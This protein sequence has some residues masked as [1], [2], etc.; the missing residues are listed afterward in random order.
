MSMSQFFWNRWLPSGYSDLGPVQIPPYPQI[1][2]LTDRADGSQWLVSFNATTS[3]PE[4]LSISSIFASIQKSEGARV[5]GIDDGPYIGNGDYKL[6]IR[7]GRI[8]LEY[9]PF[10]NGI[11]DFNAP[12]IYAET[13]TRSTRLVRIDSENPSVAHIKYTI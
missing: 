1:V 13:L 7:G 9:I 10:P 12:P 2:V 11:E 3:I 4:R 6:I 5:Y 8:G